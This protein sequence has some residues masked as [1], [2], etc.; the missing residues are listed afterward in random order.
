MVGHF[1]LSTFLEY[2]FFQGFVFCSYLIIVN[3]A[4]TS[5]FLRDYLQGM[6]HYPCYEFQK[7]L[8]IGGMVEH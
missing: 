4:P 2:I 8:E 1:V 5:S 3:E 6:S 7:N